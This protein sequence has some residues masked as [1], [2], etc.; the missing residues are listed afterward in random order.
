MS[1]QQLTTQHTTTHGPPH[2]RRLFVMNVPSGQ[3][4]AAFGRKITLTLI[5]KKP[6]RLYSSG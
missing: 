5:E 4:N 2:L 1:D 6:T 3:R